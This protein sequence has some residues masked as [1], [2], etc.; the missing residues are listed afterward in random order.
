MAIHPDFKKQKIGAGELRTPVSF[1][2][3]QPTD[4]PD[5]GDEEKSELYAC[6][7]QIY[8]PS[9]KDMEIMNAKG[10]KEAVTIKIRDPRGDYLPTNKNKVMIDDYRYAG[11]VWEIVDVSPD[12]E[13][14]AFI[15]II[16]GVTS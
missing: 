5:P 2:E 8:N 14:N 11:I 4:G 13:D 12:F 15:K 16:L 7:A 6:T 1:F 3:Y 9:M 10:T